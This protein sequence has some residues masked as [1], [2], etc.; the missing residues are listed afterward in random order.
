MLIDSTPPNIGV[1]CDGL[2][3]GVDL[4]FSSTAF[5]AQAHW[6]NFTD[7]E[8]SISHYVITVFYR[9]MD[10]EYTL[11]YTKQLSNWTQEVTLDRFTFDTGYHVLLQ[12]E[13]YNLAGLVTA[14]NTTGVTI[15]L[16]APVVTSLNDVFATLSGD[17]EDYQSVNHTYNMNWNAS[18]SESTIVRIDVALF[19][20]SEGRRVVVYP[21]A[22]RGYEV[23]P[24]TMLT[25]TV[26]VWTVEDLN[27]T[28][29]RTYVGSL[30][31]TNG[32][33]LQLR[34][35]TNGIIVDT[36]PP[37]FQSVRVVGTIGELSEDTVNI[38]ATDVIEGRWEA[39]DRE[40]NLIR[41]RAGIR[42]INSRFYI[43]PNED[44]LVDFGYSQG[45]IFSDLTLVIGNFYQLE[46]LAIDQS[47][48]FSEM[49]TRT[50][51]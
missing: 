42:N 40:S 23:L 4:E 49:R 5:T 8:S 48:L 16:T 34:A 39:T 15:D 18:D 28:S 26:H 17:D 27:L 45:G 14:V 3:P 22:T 36:N 24:D 7:D 1:V 37:E 12:L 35:E 32:A 50:F 38:T 30:L 25:P 2:S 47:G 51:M 6:I 21:N 9:A 46:V 41:Y 20:V 43:T 44:E 33:G 31:F 11:A 10:S 13:A 29:G 19:E